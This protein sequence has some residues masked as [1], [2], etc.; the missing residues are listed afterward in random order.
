MLRTRE[1]KFMIDSGQHLEK[2]LLQYLL[3]TNFIGY[4]FRIVIFDYFSGIFN[5]KSYLLMASLLIN[6]DFVFI[7][8]NP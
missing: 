4:F 8:L 2:L 7:W 3:I 1:I 5:A 6:D